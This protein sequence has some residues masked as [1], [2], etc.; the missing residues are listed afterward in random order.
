MELLVVILGLIVLIML[1]HYN[2][3]VE[4]PLVL[5]MQDTYEIV[6]LMPVGTLVRYHTII[7]V[8]LV[9]TQQQI[10]GDV[11]IH[12]IRICTHGMKM[13]WIYLVGVQDALGMEDPVYL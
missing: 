8:V 5:V 10:H 6:Q 11:L 13:V 12:I 9:Q 4:I 3:I 2:Q 7:V 1:M